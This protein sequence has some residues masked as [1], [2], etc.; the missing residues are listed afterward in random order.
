VRAVPY[1]VPVG[2]VCC[3][4]NGASLLTNK[5]EKFR[6]SDR[7]R[8]VPVLGLVP[9]YLSEIRPRTTGAFELAMWLLLHSQFF[10]SD[11][12]GRARQRNPR[13]A[14]RTVLLMRAT[15][16]TLAYDT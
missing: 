2:G 10:C 15:I 4:P 9:L 11:N 14:S 1:P 6:A 8:N 16:L 3:K 5:V 13:I 12:G 7:Y